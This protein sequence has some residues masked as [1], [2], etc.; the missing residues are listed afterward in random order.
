MWTSVGSAQCV[1]LHFGRHPHILET[2]L[3]HLQILCEFVD[4]EIVPEAL[5]E[6]CGRV[7]GRNG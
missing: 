4:G 2:F 1:P 7:R 6:A 5:D 3:A